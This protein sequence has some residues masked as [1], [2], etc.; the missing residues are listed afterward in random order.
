M[1]TEIYVKLKIIIIIIIII[2]VLPKGRYFTGC[3]GTKVAVLPKGRFFA[4]RMEIH[5]F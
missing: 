5:T 3:S 2:S 1:A 4:G